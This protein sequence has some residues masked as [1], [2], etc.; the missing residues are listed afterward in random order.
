[1]GEMMASML[2]EWGLLGSVVLAG[3]VLGTRSQAVR[4]RLACAGS[5]GWLV[6]GGLAYFLTWWVIGFHGSGTARRSGLL[7]CVF[8]VSFFVGLTIIW[9]CYGFRQWQLKARVGT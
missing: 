7:T 2:V 5:S 4:W 8:P 3:I 1:M 9:R 6:L